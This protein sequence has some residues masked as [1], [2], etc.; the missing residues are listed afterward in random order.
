MLHFASI[1]SSRLFA[2]TNRKQKWN[3]L[4]SKYGLRLQITILIESSDLFDF[5]KKICYNIKKS[6]FFQKWKEVRWTTTKWSYSSIQFRR[7][8]VLKRV[9]F[10]KGASMRARRLSVAQTGTYGCKL[11]FFKNLCYN[12]ID[13]LKIFR[14]G[15]RR[16]G[17]IRTYAFLSNNSICRFFK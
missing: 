17:T 6:L 15:I 16:P 11:D 13:T 3:L 14:A 4:Q 1:V 9:V 8:L 2:N 5:I 12:R 7:R 10:Q